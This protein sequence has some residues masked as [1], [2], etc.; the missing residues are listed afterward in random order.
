MAAAIA[1]PIAVAVP[2]GVISLQA[3]FLG[4][5]VY[6]GYAILRLVAFRIMLFFVFKMIAVITGATVTATVINP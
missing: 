1:I 2:L 5:L 4:M 3:A 6:G